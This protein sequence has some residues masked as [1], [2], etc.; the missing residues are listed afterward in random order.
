MPKRRKPKSPGPFFLK[1]PLAQ[2]RGDVTGSG[3]LELLAEGVG[4]SNSIR[5]LCYALPLVQ[6]LL[7]LPRQP[8]CSGHA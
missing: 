2:A 7:L 6:Q 8:G 4:E 1:N 3:F 5:A